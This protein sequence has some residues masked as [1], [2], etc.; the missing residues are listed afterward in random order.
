MPERETKEFEEYFPYR[1]P[2]PSA[3]VAAVSVAF[4]FFALGGF[5]RTYLALEATREELAHARQENE[6]LKNEAR[7]LRSLPVHA[8]PSAPPAAYGRTRALPPAARIDGRSPTESRAYDRRDGAAPY[9]SGPPPAAWDEGAV[10][11]PP[12]VSV[13][14]PSARTDNRLVRGEC[15]VVAVDYAGKRLHIDGGRDSGVRAG[16]ILET[17]RSGERQAELRVVQ[18]FDA[19]SVCEFVALKAGPVPGDRVRMSSGTARD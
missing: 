8:F 13:A 3:W 7:R 1:K 17:H 19:M 15:R 4:A 10:T 2:S 6:T 14:P 18:V 9:R 11:A 5:F 16:E 12:A